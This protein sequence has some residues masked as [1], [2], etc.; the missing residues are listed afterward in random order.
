MHSYVGHHNHPATPRLSRTDRAGDAEPRQLRSADQ[1]LELCLLDTLR[2][3]NRLEEIVHRLTSV[4]GTGGEPPSGVVSMLQEN[5]RRLQREVDTFSAELHA[6]MKVAQ[7]GVV[8]VARSA[9]G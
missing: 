2:Q 4:A 8:P 6:G 9:E 5:N 1:T 3:V 7:R